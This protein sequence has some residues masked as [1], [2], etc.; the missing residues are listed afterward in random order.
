MT[1]KETFA[2]KLSDILVKLNALKQDE[3]LALHISF[4]R[5]AK[6]NFD[7]FLIEE[8]LVEKDDILKALAI[9][10]QVPSFDVAGY[11]F[12]HNLLIKFPKDFLL[13]CQIIPL[14]VDENIMVMVANEPNNQELL[15]LIG[16]H[17]SYDIQFRVGIAT[18]ITDAVKEF[19]DRSLTD[20]NDD[21]DIKNELRDEREADELIFEIEEDF[22]DEE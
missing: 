13:R 16:E 2:Q 20:I 1:K 5:S 6:E 3:A 22:E 7:D 8:G 10:Y 21:I 18:D 4:A 12:D 14:E 9:Y 17:V 15:P 19:Y 11:L